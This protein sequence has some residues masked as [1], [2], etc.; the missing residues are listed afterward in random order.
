MNYIYTTPV[1]P[2]ADQ[3]GKRVPNPLPFCLIVLAFFL[4]PNHILAHDKSAADT[5]S[6]PNILVILTDDQR[7]SGVGALGME[8]VYTPNMDNLVK[9][10]TCFTQAHIMGGLQGAICAP[11]RAMLMTSKTLF[12]QRRDGAYIPDHFLLMPEFFRQQGYATFATGKWHNGKSSFNR[13]FAQ[14][15]NI[16]FGG[17]H[18]LARGGHYTPDLNHYDSSG[19]YDQPFKGDHFSS[20]Y[21]ADAVISFLHQQHA[22]SK[23]FFAY[24]AFTAPH[25]PRQAP[26][27]FADMYA[28][29]KIKLPVNFKP[30]HPFDNGELTIRDEEL[31]PHPRTPEAVRKEIAAYYAMIT[32][33]DEQ[34]G[35]ILRALQQNDLLKN[36]LIVFAGDN[37]LAVGQHGLLGKQNLYEHSVRV[38][39]VITGPGIPENKKQERLVYLLDIFPSLCEL[40]GFS[41]PDST[42]GR[43]FAGVLG[44]NASPGTER[45]QVLLVYSNLQ[46]G[47]K[48]DGFKLIE[49]NVN[50][51]PTTQLFDLKKDPYELNNLSELPAYQK[52][53]HSMRQSLAREMKDNDDFCD[54]NKPGWGHPQKMSYEQT[55]E[56]NH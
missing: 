35:R 10:G 54:L 2:A 15:D 29:A 14:G 38:P 16:F 47:L 53:L 41:V 50:G 27:K 8:K 52:R 42:E 11:S 49:Y 32:E 33:V 45:N 26:Q 7:F 46:R 43:S 44:R 9:K 3:S 30:D 37:G 36:T 13:A 5:A 23:P 25:D 6:H 48:K 28:P 12:H 56:L 18:T 55:M 22:P 19:K 40:S 39:L 1:R 17:M 34:I 24:V 4:C 31:L 20:E 51:H 21:F